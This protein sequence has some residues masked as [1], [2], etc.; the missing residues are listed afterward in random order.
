MEQYEIS[1]QKTKSYL[2]YLWKVFYLLRWEWVI[3]NYL[4]DGRGHQITMYPPVTFKKTM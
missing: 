2:F 3:V 4:K 1:V